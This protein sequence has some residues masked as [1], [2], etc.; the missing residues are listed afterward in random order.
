MIDLEAIRQATPE[1]MPIIDLAGYDETSPAG[2]D[3]LGVEI[4]DALR[5]SG[6]LV[7]VNHGLRR[8]VIEDAFAAAAEFHALP[9]D[10]KRALAMGDG[11]VG[12]LPSGEYVIRTSTVNDN[13]KPDVNAA[14]FFDRERQPDDAEIRAGI[15]FRY[16]NKWPE[17]MT[18]F[19]ERC[20]RY[21]Y[22]MEALSLS[23][24]PALAS[25]LG[26]PEDYFAEGFVSPQ[27][28]VRMSHYPAVPYARNQFG[29][30]PHTDSCFMTFL[31]QS[32]VEGLYIRAR[33][34]WVKAPKIDGAI[35]VNS[36][37]FLK[38][39]TNDSIQSTQHFAANLSGRAR[40][41]LPFFISPNTRY[42]ISTMPTCV[43]EGTEPKYP[44]ICYEEQR[45]WFMRSNYQQKAAS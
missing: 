15:P 33:D 7:L 40:Y 13:D 12:Y 39:W 18:G 34:G 10:T 29:I 6:F 43:L 36:G 16:V 32:E 42:Q 9:M 35:S 27:A 20:L 30:A 24:L 28:T 31:P 44:P 25:G 5:T 8:S 1:E 45:L 2:V 21:F 38:R 26:M 41:A 3:R 19:R 17:G 37:D 4:V 11:F 14:F 22:N 23:L